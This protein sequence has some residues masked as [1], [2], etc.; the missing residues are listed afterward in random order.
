MIPELK[1]GP[2]ELSVF[3]K[4]FEQGAYC[5]KRGNK[6]WLS[7]IMVKD[8]Y[9]RQGACTRLLEDAKK[10]EGIKIVIIPT[11][12][13]IVTMAAMKHGYKPRILKADPKKE[14]GDPDWLP[15]D[16]EA[17]IWS[18]ELEKEKD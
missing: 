5:W 13:T 17:M 2:N 18:E 11:P 6:L 7:L 1:E 14:R 9:L 8:K 10:V 16:I 12:S 15:E 4:E 3:G